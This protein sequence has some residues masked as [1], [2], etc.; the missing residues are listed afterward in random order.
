MPRRWRLRST[1]FASTKKRSPDGS[2]VTHSS[3]GLRAIA[4][5]SPSCPHTRISSW[6]GAGDCRVGCLL[7]L[8]PPP[9]LTGVSRPCPGLLVPYLISSAPAVESG[10]PL[11]GGHPPGV[12]Y[13]PQGLAL[14]DLCLDGLAGGS[15][16]GWLHCHPW[17]PTRGVWSP[18]GWLPPA[19]S[20]IRP[21]VLWAGLCLVGSLWVHLGPLWVALGRSG[22]L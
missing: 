22:S 6:F 5:P 15:L 10:R 9:L 7:H 19:P 11:P 13:I 18:M 3:R 14:R 1:A 4:K 20:P 17:A 16:T 21:S 2:H 12:G 8:D